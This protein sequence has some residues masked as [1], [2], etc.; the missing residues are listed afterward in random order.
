MTL[1]ESNN[2]DLTLV[3]MEVDVVEKEMNGWLFSSK[4][5]G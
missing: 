2:L 3:R 5:A 4:L 1:G